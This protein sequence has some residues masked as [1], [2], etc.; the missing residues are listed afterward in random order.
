MIKNSSVVNYGQ[1][2]FS[3]SLS[4]NNATRMVSGVIGYDGSDSNSNKGAIYTFDV[5]EYIPVAFTGES[6]RVYNNTAEIQFTISNDDTTENVAE[7]LSISL[8]NASKD[9]IEIPINDTSKDKSW[10]SNLDRL[11]LMKGQIFP[12]KLRDDWFASRRTSYNLDI[13]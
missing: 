6:F 10:D 5:K 7:F 2:G 12:N 9:S 8:D 1:L 3:V 13:I 11:Q 4:E